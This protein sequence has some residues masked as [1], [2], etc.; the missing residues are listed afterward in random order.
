MYQRL[1]ASQG[2]V[3]LGY[4]RRQQL[5]GRIGVSEDKMDISMSTLT[6]ERKEGYILHKYKDIFLT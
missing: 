6:F 4:V 3:D 2:I 5:T 1:T